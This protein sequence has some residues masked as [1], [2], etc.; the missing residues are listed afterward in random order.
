VSLLTLGALTIPFCFFS[1]GQIVNWLI[2]VQIVSQFIWQCAGVMLL[3]R[4]RR[5]VPQPF[6][7]WLYPAP[8]LTALALWIYVFVSAPL[9]GILFALGF[10][11]AGVAAYFVF[12]P[13]H[14]HENTK[15]ETTK[16]E[17]TK[18]T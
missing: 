10:V 3:R 14:G 8:A 1:L 9:G 17:T 15:P 13:T 12:D 5:D 11:A 18:P 16:P 6:M 7:M 4:Y 2:L